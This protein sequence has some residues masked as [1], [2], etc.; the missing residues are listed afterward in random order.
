MTTEINQ[1]LMSPKGLK[2][3]TLA[4]FGQRYLNAMRA[5]IP[6]DQLP[7]VKFTVDK[8]L[9]NLWLVGYIQMLLP[10]SCIVHVMRHPLDAALSCYAQPFGYSGVSWSWDLQHIAEQVEMVWELADHWDK[11]YPGGLGWCVCV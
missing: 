1:L 3:K 7:T 2:P 9:R 5:R 6:A 4:T 8:M 11:Y 10:K